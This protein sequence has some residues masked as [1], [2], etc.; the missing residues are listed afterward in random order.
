MKW[1]KVKV[2]LI[3]L[4]IFLLQLVR[5]KIEIGA[6]ENP[7]GYPFAMVRI[8][9]SHNIFVVSAEY[10]I[11]KIWTFAKFENLLIVAFEIVMLAIYYFS[12]EF[13]RT[14]KQRVMM[15]CHI[16]LSN[17][18][19]LYFCAGAL[20]TILWFVLGVVLELVLCLYF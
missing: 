10:L 7:V 20:E 3:E 17:V 13:I 18:V 15:L 6:M 19:A 12:I 2:W 11:S 16:G 9:Y 1:R 8:F 5:S 14:K 4:S